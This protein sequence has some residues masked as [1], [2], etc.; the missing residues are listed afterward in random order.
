MRFGG[1]GAGSRLARWGVRGALLLSLSSLG[2]GA[3]SSKLLGAPVHRP[4]ALVFRATPEVAA[5]ADRRSLQAFGQSLLE[6]LREKG[7]VGCLAPEGEPA[8]APRLEFMVERWDALGGKRLGRY[9]AGVIFG[10]PAAVAS[11][12]HARDVQVDCSVVREGET[13]AA[14]HYLFIGE[15][16]D[17]V[18]SEILTR[19]FTDETR[20]ERPVVR[21][22]HGGA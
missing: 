14:D 4:I 20:L 13:A 21:G 7:L 17:D 12:V 10:L 11:L 22:G 2:C 9:A 16:G 3:G 5:R 19:V 15:T 8:P 18:A 1:E 6:G